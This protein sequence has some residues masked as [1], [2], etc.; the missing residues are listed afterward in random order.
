[1]VPDSVEREVL[2][3][4]PVDVV[5]AI[6]IEPEHI[7]QWLGNSAEIDARPGG[8]AAF[9]WERHG[10]TRARV[11]QIDAPHL[12]A[13]RWVSA[14]SARSGEELT[15]GN[16]TLVEFHLSAEDECTR[17]RVVES[18][19][20]GLDGSENQNAAVAE[21]HDN[22]WGRELG[23]LQDYVAQVRT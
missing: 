1:M 20:P 13:F 19:F 14:A 18:G 10:V 3:E 12:F 4:A 16:S 9:G 21:D 11:E 2:I 15:D 6:V 5:W 7:A 23:D 8:D 22:G 17:L